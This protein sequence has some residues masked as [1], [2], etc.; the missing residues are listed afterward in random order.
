M[1]KPKPSF[2]ANERTK[3]EVDAIAIPRLMFLALNHG[4]DSPQVLKAVEVFGS[5]R[6]D[7]RG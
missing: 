5:M 3:K 1:A 4:A 7:A 2:S 6:D